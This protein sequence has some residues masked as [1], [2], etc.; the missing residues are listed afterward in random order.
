M[1]F[2]MIKG[3]FLIR[4]MIILIPVAFYGEGE[5]KYYAAADTKFNQ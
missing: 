3:G 1:L 5:K 4:Y 2:V